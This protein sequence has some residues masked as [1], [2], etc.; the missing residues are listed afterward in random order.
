MKIRITLVRGVGV[1]GNTR[2]PATKKIVCEFADEH[3]AAN[4]FIQDSYFAEPY[5]IS[6]LWER[7]LC[8][9]H[10]VSTHPGE[11]KHIRGLTNPHCPIHRKEIGDNT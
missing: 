9:Q 8:D 7:C 11:P 2:H 6:A 4:W 5:T 1:M 10:D 3:E